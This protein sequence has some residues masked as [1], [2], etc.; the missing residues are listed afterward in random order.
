MQLAEAQ[1]K[2]EMKRN[3]LPKPL[4]GQDGEE[5]SQSEDEVSELQ[6]MELHNMDLQVYTSDMYNARDI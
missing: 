5:A 1:S 6:Q 2:R 4:I 3:S